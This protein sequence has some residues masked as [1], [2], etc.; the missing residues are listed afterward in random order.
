VVC[1]Q[2][3]HGN[4]TTTPAGKYGAEECDT[5]AATLDEILAD[6]KE[7]VAS[8]EIILITGGLV[9]RDPFLS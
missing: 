3:K 4:S 8:P 2:A 5:P 6:V 9:S 7:K 1:C